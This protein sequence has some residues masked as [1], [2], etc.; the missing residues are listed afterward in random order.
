MIIRSPSSSSDCISSDVT[1]EENFQI[2]AITFIL[3]EPVVGLYRFYMPFSG[4]ITETVV[5]VASGSGTITTGIDGVSVTGISA[6]VSDTAARKY[7]ATGANTFTNGQY[8]HFTVD[9]NNAMLY[10]EV[11]IVYRRIYQ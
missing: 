8:I 2:D 6:V 3:E 9:T 1:G 7:A 11:T 4:I 5:K 10:L